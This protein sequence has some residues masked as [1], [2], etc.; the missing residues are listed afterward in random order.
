MEHLKEWDDD[1]LLAELATIRIASGLEKSATVSA[2]A[3]PA[4]NKEY[5][6]NIDFSKEESSSFLELDPELEARMARARAAATVQPACNG[7]VTQQASETRIV[8]SRI[9]RVL[10]TQRA[11]LQDAVEEAAVAVG[12]R[13]RGVGEDTIQRRAKAHLA[14]LSSSSAAIVDLDKDFAIVRRTIEEMISRPPS[15]D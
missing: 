12:A 6:V 4:P 13:E 14:R 9:A 8:L 3:E 5:K 7:A 1:G 10:A 15:S 11:S 2:D